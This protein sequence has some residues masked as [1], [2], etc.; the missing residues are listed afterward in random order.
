M[1]MASVY[2]MCDMYDA[3]L[4][5]IDYLLSLETHFTVNDIKMNRVFDPLKERPEFQALMKKY[6]LPPGT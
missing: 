5:E 2:T 6:A 3:A 1:V 4:E